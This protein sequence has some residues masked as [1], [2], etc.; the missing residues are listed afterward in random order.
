MRPE[1]TQPDIPAL[2]ARGHI[3][4]ERTFSRHSALR[5]P[6]T[7]GDHMRPNRTRAGSAKAA[8]ANT[9]NSWPAWSRLRDLALL[10][11]VKLIRPRRPDCLMWLRSGM[12]GTC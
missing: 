1:H 3:A 12:V 11:Y 5:R 6:A 10:G 9:L 2:P 7:K 4:P 8:T